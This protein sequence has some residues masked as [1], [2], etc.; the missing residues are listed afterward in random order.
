M[1]PA[2]EPSPTAGTAAL[3]IDVERVAVPRVPADW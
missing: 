2:S 3:A 1:A